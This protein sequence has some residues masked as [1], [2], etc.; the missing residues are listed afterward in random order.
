MK[1]ARLALLALAALSIQGGLAAQ[2]DPSGDDRLAA[3]YKKKLDKDFAKKTPWL[4]TFEEAKKTAAKD[5]KLILG[6]FTRSYAPCPPCNML[7]A[8]PL[9]SEWWTKMAGQFVPYLN[10]T[11]MID[12]TPDQELLEAKGGDGFPYMIFMDSSG[13]VLTDRI[14]PEDEAAVN[15]ALEGARKTATELQALRLKVSQ[16]PG[17]AAASAALEIQLTL[18]RAGTSTDEELEKLARTPGLEPATLAKLT[19]HLNRKNILAAQ[20]K[21]MEGAETQEDFIH[22]IETAMY[23]CIKKDVLLP[24]GDEMAQMLYFAGFEGALRAK[25][26]A[27]AKKALQGVVDVIA[28]MKS[29]NPEIEERAGEYLAELKSRLEEAEAGSPKPPKEEKEEK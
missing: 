14:W 22:R 21:A 10:V 6:Y 4:H 5:G 29:K 23:E 11:T 9:V 16:N 13:A 24:A 7:E 20:R 25:D 15:T 12:G 3:E 28:V 1:P 17:D 27:L 8:G 26:T 2:T 18:H 19:T